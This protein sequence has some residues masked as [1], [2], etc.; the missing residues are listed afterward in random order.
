MKPTHEERLIRS[1]IF[2]MRNSPFFSTLVLNTPVSLSDDIG[3]AATDG[4]NI[5]I[6]REFMDKLTDQQL[7]GVLCHEVLHMAFDHL[8]RYSELPDPPDHPELKRFYFNYAADI[9]VNGVVL[10]V[11]K[12]ELI[13]GCVVNHDLEDFSLPEVYSKILEDPPF[14][15][16]EVNVCM[17]GEGEGESDSE[18]GSGGS[19]PQ[20]SAAEPGNSSSKGKSKDKSQSKDKEHWDSLLERAK[21][22]EEMGNSSSALLRKINQVLAESTLDYRTIL[23]EWIVPA[24]SS[25][26]GYDRR[27]IYN[28]IYIDSDIADTLR[29]RI[30]IDT[31]GSV[32]LE[33]LSEFISEIRDNIA[34]SNW[35]K[36]DIEGYFFDTELY[37]PYDDLDDLLNPRGYGGTDF[38]Q[39]VNLIEESPSMGSAEVNIVFTDGHAEIPQAE[40]SNLIW[41]LGAYQGM[42]R[43]VFDFISRGWNH[44]Y[45][46]R[47]NNND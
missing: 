43:K 13:D 30:F 21:Q 24:S 28:D 27:H 7:T 31:S 32:H 1:R 22:A 26:G 44:V 29:L 34:M 45:K 17:D 11:P 42:T 10:S 9:V 6:G 16:T 4:N 3:T 5:I 20:D 19:D 14:N 33:T 15:I 25:W 35:A 18:Q 37:G 36:V 41:I 47:S 23:S 46:F 40:F 39:I 12:L 2:L 38:H 8:G